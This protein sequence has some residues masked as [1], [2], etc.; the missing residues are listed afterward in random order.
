LTSGNAPAA[1]A[2]KLPTITHPPGRIDSAVVSPTPPG[3]AFEAGSDPI[4]ANVFTDP[5]GDT[6]TIVLPVPCTFALLLKLLT[7]VSPLMSLPTVVGTT[8]M[9]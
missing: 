5:A 2:G 1:P 7:S 6:S 3:H 4:V 9:P 8:A